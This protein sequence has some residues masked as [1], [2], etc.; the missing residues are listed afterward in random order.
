MSSIEKSKVSNL[1]GVKMPSDY[2]RPSSSEPK[3]IAPRE[4]PVVKNPVTKQDVKIAIIVPF[5]DAEK[6]KP[7]TAQLTRLV[8]WMKVYLAGYDYKIFVIEQSDDGRKFNRGQLLNVGFVLAKSEGYTN[9]I[10]HDVDLIPIAGLKE[11][12]ITNPQD[13]PVH[14]AAVWDR[15]GTNPNYF[16]GIVAF[17]SE[18]FERINGFPNNFWG[19]GGEDDELLKRTKKFY[20]IFKV[21]KGRIQDL[22]NLNLDL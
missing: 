10:F 22:E 8:E 11:Y 1:D 14:I 20:N 3:T 9:F 19:W 6:T 17:N 18:M 12:Y 7:R 2:L 16:G 13:K 4:T 21:A 15:Y 5:R